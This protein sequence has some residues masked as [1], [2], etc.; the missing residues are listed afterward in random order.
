MFKRLIL[1]ALA[2]VMALGA[3]ARAEWK[4]ERPVAILVA[5]AA[6]GGG[7]IIARIYASLLQEELGQQV[8][9]I[10][11]PGA[12]G[13]NGTIEMARAKPDGYTL[14]L[15]GTNLNFHG[16]QQP[17]SVTPNDFIPVALINADAQGYQVRA[18]S[19]FKTLKEAM[20]A[21][22]ANPSRFKFSASGIGGVW[23]VGLLKLIMSQGIEPKDIIF[24]P[25]GGGGPSINEL[26][27]GGVDVAP[28]SVAE[29]AVQMKSG[30]LRS[31]AVLSDERLAAFPDIPTVKEAIGVDVQ[32]YGWR[33]FVLPKGTPD[34]VVATITTAVRNVYNSPKFKEEMDK[35]GFNMS[36]AEGADFGA[37]MKR[38]YDAAGVALKAAGLAK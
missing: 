19:P 28:T 2:S 32:N 29:A 17:G 6:G 23:H 1:F 31:L 11:R 21:L 12:G 15:A 34:D 20:D 36:Y 3:S 22:K 18:D 7:D 27:A 30:Q 37:F 14:G 9:V 38:E 24:V 35:L 10:N 26:I 25:T 13:L 8:N 33:G 5:F 4:P 16:W